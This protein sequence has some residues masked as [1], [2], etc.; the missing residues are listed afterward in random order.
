MRVNRRTLQARSE[1]GTSRKPADEIAKALLEQRSVTV[2]DELD[3]GRRVVNAVETAAAQEKAQAMQERFAQWCW[4]DPGRARRLLGEYNRRFNSIVLRDY[5]ADGERLTLPGLVR[6]FTPMPHQ[7]AAVARMLSEPAVGL[8]HQVGAGKTAEM[9]IGASEL[10]RLGMVRKPVVVVPNHML[11][12]FSREWLQLFPQARVLTASSEDLAAERRRRFVARAASNDWD[13][14]LMTRSAFERIPVS[15]KT[16]QR[17]ERRQLEEVRAMLESARA[18][19]GG[20]LTVKRLEKM[21]LSQEQQLKK[22]LDGNKDTGVTFEETGIDYVIVDEAHGYKN[23]ATVSNIRDARIEGSKRSSDL[24]MKLEWLRERHGRRVATMATATPI[25]NSITEAHVM[26]R[27]LR[28]DLLQAAGVEHFDAWAATFGQT[29]TEIEMAPTGGGSYRLNTRF[30]RFQN[31]PEML[32]MW[33]VFADVKTGEDLRLP[34]PELAATENGRA[35]PANR[36]D[37]AEPGDRRLPAAARRPRRQG[38]RPGSP[39]G[40][41]QHA[42]DLHRRPQGRARHAAGRRRA[43]RGRLQARYRRPQHR[44]PLRSTPSTSPTPTPTAGSRHRSPARCRSCSATSQPQRRDGTHTTNC[45]ACSQSTGSHATGSAPSTRP[46]TTPRRAACSPRA[47]A[48]MSPC[49]S[50]RPRRWAS[51]P[52]SRPERSRFTT[53]TAHGGPPTS[54]ILLLGMSV[55]SVPHRRVV[56]GAEIQPAAGCGGGLNEPDGEVRRWAVAG[57]ARRSGGRR[58][59]GCGRDRRRL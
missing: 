25:A 8:F 16:Q 44:P 13:G 2:T 26:Q 38:A 6:T 14:I 33:H 41:G 56:P 54:S 37:R 36:G 7:R 45:E 5:T 17:Y 28:P 42:E 34:V 23:L 57:G 21:V 27:Y 24:H 1:W 19:K 9:V 53:S 52:T 30:A 55:S 50:A 40:G 20:S 47:A 4:E 12:Q 51:A 35:D 46:A 29:V 15:P 43:D 11:A 49:S 39:P 3:D 18:V 10:R 59:R 58:T 48:D 22:R 31:V 32:R